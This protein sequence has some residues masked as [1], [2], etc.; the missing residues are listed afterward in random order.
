MIPM[1]PFGIRSFEI[2][3]GPCWRISLDYI[4]IL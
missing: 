1:S 4:K 2:D 3:S